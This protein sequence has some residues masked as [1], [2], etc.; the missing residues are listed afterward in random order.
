MT[1]FDPA[2]ER[3]KFSARMMLLGQSKRLTIPSEDEW[4][5]LNL[6]ERDDELKIYRKEKGEIQTTQREVE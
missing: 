1:G 3:Y 6:L 4:V 2:E 5:G